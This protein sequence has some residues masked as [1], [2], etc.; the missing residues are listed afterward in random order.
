VS[1]EPGTTRDYLE[2]RIILGAHGLRLIDTAGLNPAPAAL[3]KLGIAQTHAR[4]EEADL[5]LWVVDATLPCPAL[6]DDIAARLHADNTLILLNKADL[7]PPGTCPQAVVPK[8]FT[9]FTTLTL[10]TLR[11]EGFEA[12]TEAIGRQADTFR[13]D[14]G[15]D[16]I[17]INTRHADALRRAHES[18]VAALALLGA[19]GPTELL[20]S[21]LRSALAALGEIAGKIDNERVLDHL[22]ASFCIGK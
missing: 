16:V 13:L 15:E 20:S 10:S 12:L 19:H 22:F 9:A 8:A 18:L 21:D 14:Q 3:E 2:E 6:P 11:G 7:L 1:A 17:A 5:F 4:T